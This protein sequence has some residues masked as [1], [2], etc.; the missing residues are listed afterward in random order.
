MRDSVRRV[1]CGSFSFLIVKLIDHS[2]GPVPGDG[3]VEAYLSADSILAQA[4]K[5][6]GTPEGYT[7]SF[8]NLQGSTQQVGY[9]TYRTIDSG[10][11]DVDAC[12]SFCDSEKFCLGFNIY[13]ERDPSL[14]ADEGCANPPPVTNVKC[15]LYGYPVAEKS[16]TNTGQWRGPQDTN[17][18]A[19]HVVIAGSNGY[20]KS[21]GS[22]TLPSFAGPV[23]LP[24]AI[25]A[26]LDNGYDTYNGM[27][28]YNEGPFDPTLCAA[29]CQAQTVF[30]REHLV[31]A[32]GTYKPCNFFTAYILTKNDV[33]QG[34]Y[35]SFYTRE[36]DSSYAVNT[37]YFWEQ[38]VYSVKNTVAYTLTPLD[39]GK[40]ASVPEPSAP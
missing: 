34:T 27:K 7:K 4:A 37:G 26:P 13:F 14:D 6:A 35:C 29:A 19:F 31:A 18:E 21:G 8:T 12:K 1:C 9:L 25:N 11:Y 16:A 3:S 20:S 2:A 39:S 32:D 33:P 15:S 28:L 5:N 23:S 30:D 22:P 10:L 40:V 36:W 17:G 24:A 38:D